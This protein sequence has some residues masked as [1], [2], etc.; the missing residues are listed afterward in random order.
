MSHLGSHGSRV[1]PNPPR[2]APELL[3]EAPAWSASASATPGDLGADRARLGNREHTAVQGYPSFRRW[4][5]ARR[6][7]LESP[8]GSGALRCVEPRG[9]RVSE[10]RRERYPQGE[11]QVRSTGVPRGTPQAAEGPHGC[12]AIANGLDLRASRRGVAV[13]PWHSGRRKIWSVAW[14]PSIARVPRVP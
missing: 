6:S 9:R 4:Q 11:G 2:E 12:R 1:A 8:P 3:P 14:A 13:A 7:T 10:T 5:C